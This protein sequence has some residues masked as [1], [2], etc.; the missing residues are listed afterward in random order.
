MHPVNLAVSTEGIGG[1]LAVVN[2]VVRLLI[3]GVQE[4]FEHPL[5]GI[6]VGILLICVLI[7]I[8][9]RIVYVVR[10]VRKHRRS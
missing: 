4:L 10:D 1:G 6:L 8:V 3:W 9:A 7:V 5:L 2:L